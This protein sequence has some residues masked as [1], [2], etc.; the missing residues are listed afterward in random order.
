[1]VGLRHRPKGMGL[2]LGGPKEAFGRHQAEGKGIAR[3]LAMGQMPPGVLTERWDQHGN[4]RT[5]P[6]LPACSL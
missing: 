6:G 5:G 2:P 3:A 1:M 4:S